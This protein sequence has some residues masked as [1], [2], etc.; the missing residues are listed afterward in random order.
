ML[1]W[2][3]K[4]EAVVRAEEEA[5]AIAELESTDSQMTEIRRLQRSFLWPYQRVVSA[6][7]FGVTSGLITIIFNYFVIVL[8]L[9]FQS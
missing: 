2:W 8:L 3:E 6:V 7:A 9:H 4:V 5:R 1:P